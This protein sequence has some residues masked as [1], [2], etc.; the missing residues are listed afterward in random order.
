[1]LQFGLALGVEY[2]QHQF[3]GVDFV[4]GFHCDYLR[5]WLRIARPQALQRLLFLKLGLHLLESNSKIVRE[6]PCLLQLLACLLQLSL[7]KCSL[8]LDF[9][10]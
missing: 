7:P 8:L 3:I 6:S 1:L 5:R 2:W 9:L 10:L 4:F